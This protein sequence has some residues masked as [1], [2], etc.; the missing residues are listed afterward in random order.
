MTSV[1]IVGAGPVGLILALKLAKQGITSVVFEKA[2]YLRR[3]G[4]KACLI[5]G[6]V[7]D[8][9]RNIGCAHLIAERG[10]RWTWSWTY[11]REKTIRAT[12]F[13]KNNEFGP[14]INISQYEVE[15]ILRTLVQQ[16][17]LIELRSGAEVVGIR[18]NPDLVELE[19]VV[20]GQD[21][22]QAPARDA[23]SYVVGC[24]GVKSKV[25]EL[26]KIPWRGYTHPGQFLI[27]DI[28]ADISLAKGR[29][30]HFDPKF[31][32]GRQVIMHP[33]PDNVWRIDW[34]LAPGADIARERESGDFD[35]RVHSAIGPIPY[36]IKWLSSY[37]FNQRLAGQLRAH[38]I[39]LAGDAAHALPPYGSRG[40]NSGI[41]DAENLAWK[42][43]RVLH[44]R[45]S[46][47][48]LDSYHRERHAAAQ[49][50]IDITEATLK[51][52]VPSDG[53]ATW[54]RNAVLQAARH[55]P[56]LRNKVNSGHLSTPARYPLRHRSEEGD[57]LLGQYAPDVL[58]TEKPV[59]WLRSLLGAGFTVLIYAPRPAAIAALVAQ[60]NAQ[61]RPTDLKIVVVVTADY[62][63]ANLPPSEVP[64]I[65]ILDLLGNGRRIYQRTG[66][67]GWL[68][69]PDGYICKKIANIPDLVN[70]MNVAA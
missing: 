12:E 49:E 17:N 2:P 59:M 57:S 28:Q 6:D 61:P 48:L 69:R 55:V 31:N 22:G 5:Q 27:T 45:S 62:E 36:E 16:S 56:L 34:Q 65:P 54:K 24:D 29:H 63:I 52:M 7:M 50:N 19:F 58:F 32:P 21:P 67:L 20:L 42:L 66:S 35:E 41:A 38:R 11:I 25:R 53:V 37:R 47:D 60:I 1:G 4:S 30:F 43:S 3:Q 39:F 9:L 23:F 10:V 33:Q 18:Q 14:F 46:V 8:L 44:R 40:L 70:S 15:K 51:F 64:L 68:I 13:P 26:A